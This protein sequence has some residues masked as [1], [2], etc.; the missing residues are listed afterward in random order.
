MTSK[1]NRENAFEERVMLRDQWL[2]QFSDN[3][4]HVLSLGLSNPKHDQ[5]ITQVV[6]ADIL[7]SLGIP[8]GCTQSLEERGF[9]DP[10]RALFVERGIIR[11]DLPAR[12]CNV[13]RKLALLKFRIEASPELLKQFN[14]SNGAVSLATI[15]KSAIAKELRITRVHAVLSDF[16]QNAEFQNAVS[17][18]RAWI[19][20]KMEEYELFDSSDF[21]PYN[22]VVKARAKR[23]ASR[24]ISLK[25]RFKEA[26]SDDSYNDQISSLGELSSW[27]ALMR[28]FALASKRVSA[29]SSIGN[30]RAT[31]RSLTTFLELNDIAPDSR[32]Q[33]Y[34]NDYTAVRYKAYLEETRLGVDLQPI[35]ATNYISCLNLTLQRLTRFD[36]FAENSFIQVSGFSSGA[37]ATTKGKATAYTPYSIVERDA[38][39]STLNNEINEVVE[40]RLSGYVKSTKVHDFISRNAK[41][42]FVDS[43]KLSI[44]VLKSWF[45]HECDSKPFY[46][47][48]IEEARGKSTPRGIFLNAC[49][50]LR[51]SGELTV[52]IPELFALWKVP[53]RKLTAKELFPFYLRMIQVTGMNPS[54]V[55]DLEI[56]D[57][58]S[59][60]DA[61]NRPCLRY[62]KERSTGTKEYHL[63]LF[64][65]D[66][67]WLSMSQA[68]SVKQIFDQ[69]IALTAFVR[70]ELPENQKN[71]LW[72]VSESNVGT[73]GNDR[74]QGSGAAP[75]PVTRL[76][77]LAREF[78]EKILADTGMSV[79]L[80]ASRFRSS[81][82]S[83]LIDNGVPIREIQLV[84]GHKNIQT[85]LQY[86]DRMDFNKQARHKIHEVLKK[87]YENSFAAQSEGR[88]SEI[89]LKELESVVYTTPLGGC[90]N[91]FNPPEFIKKSKSWKEGSACSNFNKCIACDNVII[92]TSHLPDLFAMY[93]DYKQICRNNT[94][95]ATP[96]GKTVIDNLD[97][98]ENLLGEKSEFSQ[99]EL[100]KA[101]RLSMNIES[102]ILIDGVSQ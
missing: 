73:K 54:S 58:V 40:S 100:S 62:W 102:T 91:V 23:V 34:L 47:T 55:Q 14:I 75:I 99:E 22:E 65:C 48:E 57:F 71:K 12:A 5:M 28:L 21:V 74:R 79:N 11:P 76:T 63:D 49:Q 95:M 61:T 53:D 80:V 17:G 2:S 8:K 64:T 84:L 82:V 41:H 15:E 38:I 24:G 25:Q 81:F 90:K 67:T 52:T 72:V 96:H 78:S 69:V 42:E 36:E 1:L 33:T 39:A 6:R 101:Q 20:E 4:E 7:K 30:Y 16:P 83:E 87:I 93:R 51:E 68:K 86:L 97:I 35:Q 66:I 45:D 94:L 89:F 46:S 85:T 70:H 98:L 31:Y 50:K 26:R 88:R 92:T 3:D 37:T 43:R 19:L 60:H 27:N 9:F 10:Y 59:S 13:L 77:S 18:V 32:L 44:E 56:N 29:E